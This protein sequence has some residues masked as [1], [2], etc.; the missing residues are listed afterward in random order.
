M[1]FFHQQQ[2]DKAEIEI[3]KSLL[4]NPDDYQAITFKDN[5]L[6]EIEARK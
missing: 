4:H 2:L 1:I 5:L 6:K 3:D